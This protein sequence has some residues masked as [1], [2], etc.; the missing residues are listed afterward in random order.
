MKNQEL[1]KLFYEIA[2]YLE[3]DK[4]AFKPYAYQKAAIAFEGMGPKRAKLFYQ[5]LG[6]RNVKE[7]EKAAKAHK[8]AALEGFGEKTEKNLL[9]GIAFLKRSKGRFLLGEI[10]PKVKEI[11]DKLKTLKEVEQISEA[12]SV[13]RRKETI[14]DVDILITA[15]NPKKV[16]DFFV[17]LSGITKIWGKG[18][19]KSSIRL[20]EGFDVDLRVVSKK[21]FGSALQYFTGSKEHN[22][23]LRTIAIEKGMKLNEYGL[24]K[25]KKMIAGWY[26]NGVYKALGLSW[27]E[28]ELREDQGELEVA[29]RG[30]LPKIIGYKDIKGDLDC[31]SAWDGGTNTIEVMA[32]AAQDMG[33]QYI[34]IAD[35][36]KFLRIENGLDEKEL[37][38]HRKERKND[39]SDEKSERRHNFPSDRQDFKEERRVP[40]RF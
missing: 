13:R 14:G 2:D 35:H 38:N 23:V 12:G 24:F 1:A 26:E 6:V 28:P 22:I 20:K 31:H 32:K 37:L 18:T 25:G 9:E 19:T 29:R 15:K 34:G 40:D 30:E 33:Y 7:L 36:T 5:K 17:Q 3:M 27:I 16:M 21:S 11:L 8:I 39:Q 4:V 10:L